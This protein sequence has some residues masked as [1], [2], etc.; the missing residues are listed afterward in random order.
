MTSHASWQRLLTL[1]LHPISVLALVVAIILATAFQAPETTRAAQPGTPSISLTKTI[2]EPANKVARAGDPVV[3]QLTLTN[4]GTTPI[5]TLPLADTFDATKLQFTGAS[6]SGMAV[7][8]SV[9][10]TGVI[11]WTDLTTLADVGDL[12]PGASL[13]V[14]TTFKALAATEP[15]GALSPIVLQS[16]VPAHTQRA[17]TE[18]ATTPNDY[19]DLE[20]RF[21]VDHVFDPVNGGIYLAVKGDGTPWGPIPEQI[22]G[23]RPRSLQG[24]SKHPGGQAT[25]IEYFVQEYQRLTDLGSSIT[26]QQ[27]VL[28]GRDMLQWAKN[29][30]DFVDN[31]LIIGTSQNEPPPPTP[32]APGVGNKC[33]YYWGFVDATGTGSY[34]P[35]NGAGVTGFSAPST[36]YLTDSYVAWTISEL[37]LALHAVG[38]P[39]YV[40]YKQHAYDFWNWAKRVGPPFMPDP[41]A[42]HPPVSYSARDRFLPNLGITLYELSVAEGA[43]DESVRNEALDCVNQRNAYA[44]VYEMRN[45]CNGTSYT[46]AYGRAGA[47]AMDLQHRG[48]DNYVGGQPIWHDYG[49]NHYGDD[50]TKPQN[51]EIPFVHGT[52][53]EFIAGTQRS[54]WFYYTF[55]NQPQPND[56]LKRIK[57]PGNWTVNSWSRNA[58][59]S[60]WNYARTNM[61]DSTPGQQSWWESQRKQYKPCLSLGTPVPLA[62]WKAP[63][64]GNKVHTLNPDGSA[65]VTISGVYD[66]DWPYL[67]W[68]F[69]GIGVQQVLV[70]YSV[71]GGATWQQLVAAETAPGSTNY[72]ATIPP[73]PGKTVYYYAEA[74]DALGNASTFPAG[75][76]GVYQLY[77]LAD[78]TL[79]A[80]WSAGATDNN[81]NTVF[82][83]QSIDSVTVEAPGPTAVTLSRFEAR[84]QQD[85]VLVEWQTNSEQDTYGFKLYRSGTADRSAATLLTPTALPGHG[86]GT[87]A[88]ASYSFVDTSPLTG[89]SSYWLEEID[90]GGTST[91]YGPISPSLPSTSA[92][93]VIYLPLVRR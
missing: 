10:G 46:T 81:G 9:Q 86:R 23:F 45:R 22:Y 41:N 26:T 31:H 32:C 15:G 58:I 5:T 24:T 73:Q 39:S 40:T 56:L 3:F 50:P 48:V 63:V 71:D 19:Y 59:L 88:G 4:T 52:G 83:I 11:S 78:T 60:Y 66:P 76:P 54:H 25:C 21:L 37:A 12:A 69:R 29:C 53:R 62:D 64:I 65:L 49:A 47:Y 38:D 28:R 77:T 42:A 90:L 72:V 17:A 44:T 16:Q 20:T 92:T 84:N 80:A 36:L 43:P 61:W 57:V 67:N 2:V 74:D 14:L 7:L 27:G 89:A 87:V 91:W 70:H 79:N 82:P 85:G 68:K 18:Q 1:Y 93:K 35:A 13:A 30:A 51:P 6:I 8:P 75:A 55:P 34:L 33:L